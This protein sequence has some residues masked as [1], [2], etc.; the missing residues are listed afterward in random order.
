[1]HMRARR[2]IEH[3]TRWWA[4]LAGVISGLAGLASPGWP[5]GWSHRPAFRS[6][7]SAN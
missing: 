2:G 5:P 3:G 7:R 4:R 6:P 1:M